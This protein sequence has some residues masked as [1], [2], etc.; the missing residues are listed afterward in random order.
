MRGSLVGVDDGRVSKWLEDVVRPH[1]KRLSDAASE[2]TQML[3]R[4]RS[5]LKSRVEGVNSGGDIE[6][7][8]SVDAII[9]SETATLRAENE[10]LKSELDWLCLRTG[11]MPRD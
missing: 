5:T 1:I 8:E 3:L 10:R 4:I 2:S 6:I 11:C 7:M 9:T